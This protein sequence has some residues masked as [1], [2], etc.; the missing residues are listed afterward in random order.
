LVSTEPP[1]IP[2]YRLH[3]DIDF[4]HATWQGTVEIP[5][6]LPAAGLELD[7]D[8]LVVLSVQR[9]GRP[10]AFTQT[11][12]RGRLT[13]PSPGAETEPLRIEFRGAVRPKA[14]IGLYRCRHAD[15]F[16]LTT[17]CEPIGARRIFPCLDRPDRK[18][19]LALT[20]RTRAD[21]EV[22]GNTA[23]TAA[24][25]QDGAREWTFETTPPMASYLFYLGVGRFDRLEDRTGRVGV[26]L[27]TPPGR[28][29]DGAYSLDAARR[30]VL[31]CEEYYATPYPLSKLDL[32]A[33][34]EHAFG[35]MEN[36]GAISFR[37][38]RLL[39]GSGSTTF[40][41][42]DVFETVAHEIAHQWFG[43]LV[44]M[45]SWDDVWL[46]ESFAS[47]VET[48]ITER[49]AP[50][51]D[52]RTDS[53]LRVAGTTAAFEGDSLPSTHPVR[54]HVERP[55]E[56]SQVFDEITYG[57]G[58]AVLGMIEAY[59][60]EER[61]RAGVTDYLQ[62]FR[63]GNARTEDLWDSLGRASGEE[64]GALIGPWIDRPGHPVIRVRTTADGLALRQDRFSLLEAPSEGPWPIP[65]RLEVDG[66]PRRL[67]F[68]TAETTLAI[69]PGA[70]VH[71]N[72]GAVG[73]YRVR[74]DAPT[75]DR[76]F[77]A[78]PGRPPADR[79][80]VVED[81][82]AFLESGEV[83]W[84]LYE[85]AVRLLG[86]TTDR[87]VVESF[88]STLY[89]LG[90][91]YPAA[92]SV[93]DVVRGYFADRLA[94]V[95]VTAVPG[96]DPSHGIL[97][98]RLSYAR[99]R[100]DLTF[101]RDVAE[102][103]PQWDSLDPNLRSAVAVARS[104]AEGAVG[105][106]ELRNAHALRRTEAEST[107]LERGLAWS[108]DPDRVA[109]TLGLI[110][111]GG[112]VRSHIV[113][114]LVQVAQNPVGRPVLWPWFRERLPELAEQFRGS[115][116]LGLLLEGVVPTL[117]LGRGTEMRAFLRNDPPPEGSRGIAKGLERLEV[118]ERLGTRLA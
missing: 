69:P 40:E 63:F 3:L 98:E 77:A 86:A 36:W 97:R 72:P 65:M 76:L 25:E 113:A 99:A 83:D 106:G 42:R 102:L 5:S 109:A 71:F 16:V 7:A 44:T 101:A 80:S 27:L 64:V 55:E 87:L 13:I 81:L 85:R 20:V 117:G 54:T 43:D 12:E 66:N 100:L 34:S 88:V 11:P 92:R 78:L 22:I 53:F 21:L 103:F 37:E 26:R 89:T 46:N 67:L 39:I 31:G 30:I 18:S 48:Q 104:R 57:K 15:D 14:L 112:I 79:W 52:A 75:Y 45:A 8:D 110:D 96:E 93:Q 17:Q 10:I 70:T 23:G 82:G 105:W 116:S 32:V 33:V 68:D 1:Q 95:G 84:P 4:E 9:G 62:R 108:S 73:F 90:L 2:E 28:G 114:T 91:L 19:R 38:V 111:S 60:G 49:L 118:F 47:F 94:A 56:I 29:A 41:R 35:A 107:Q 59:L 50:E 61:F 6:A 24:P 74:Y 115:S 51:L 58:C